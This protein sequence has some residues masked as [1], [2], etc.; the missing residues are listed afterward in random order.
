MGTCIVDFS[1]AQGQDKENVLY[2]EHRVVASVVL[3][4]VDLGC[5]QPLIFFNFSLF[6]GL[7]AGPRTAWPCQPRKLIV[8][9]WSLEAALGRTAR[10]LEW[11]GGFHFSVLLCITTQGC[12]VNI[13][14]GLE[15]GFWVSQSI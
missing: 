14:L 6:L 7:L 13:S 2:Y 9:M 4:S 3:K 15:N 1:I 10:S 12:L 8:C 11:L 5:V